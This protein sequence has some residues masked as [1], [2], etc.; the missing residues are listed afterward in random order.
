MISHKGK[1]IHWDW[2]G[3]KIWF[4]TINIRLKD[5]QL[6]DWVYK[7]N[8]IVNNTIVAWAWICMRDRG[9]IEAHLFDFDK[10]I[11]WEIVEIIFIK[12]IRWLKK[13]KTEKDL[14]TNI[15]N[16]LKKIMSTQIDVM[17]FWTFDILHKGHEHYLF[18]SKKY[19][20]KLITIVARDGTVNKVKWKMPRNDESNRLINLQKMWISDDVILW[21]MDDKY[22]CI[23]KYKP[24]IICL[25]YDQKAFIEWLDSHLESI[26]H[27]AKI[28]RI[29]SHMP[30]VYKSSKININL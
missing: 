27:K 11:Y 16:D 22:N 26:E 12:K 10:N 2:R 18:W 17:T 21:A 1:V 14:V 25:W 4:P 28:V 5:D 19:W 13:F 7:V 20:D 6:E 8:A 9:I 15:Q 29:S 3:K 23:D 24:H 30:E